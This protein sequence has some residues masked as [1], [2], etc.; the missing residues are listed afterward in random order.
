MW[1]HHVTIQLEQKVENILRSDEQLKSALK[2]AENNND[3][4]AQE[5]VNNDDS[6]SEQED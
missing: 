5:V 2:E 4:V 3:F 1:E 6:G